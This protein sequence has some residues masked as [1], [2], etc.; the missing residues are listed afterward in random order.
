MSK[1]IAADLAAKGAAYL[2]EVGKHQWDVTIG[3]NWREKIDTRALDLDSPSHCILGQ[4]FEDYHAA[5]TSL[6]K[7]A[8]WSRENG[9]STDHYGD[10]G[11][12]IKNCD[13]T[14]AWKDLL[15]GVKEGEIFVDSV[16]ST[17]ANQVVT[18]VTVGDRRHVILQTGKIKNNSFQGEGNIFTW[19]EKELLT[20]MV[21]WKPEDVAEGLVLADDVD[22]KTHTFLAKDSHGT[23]LLWRV[24]DKSTYSSL[25]ARR[26]SGWSN[27][28]MA[29]KSSGELLK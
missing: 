5:L 13:L 26:A 24:G 18:T 28:R 21:K 22:G 11:V 8:A 1:S 27:F 12:A 10:Y 9:F 7:T 3:L 15:Q 17:H 14:Q 20:S 23:L 4:I 19:E 6:N 29:R 16:G 25:S 2:D